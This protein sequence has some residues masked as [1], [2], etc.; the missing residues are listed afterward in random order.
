MLA[1]IIG[2]TNYVQFGRS[3]LTKVNLKLVAVSKTHAEGK[4]LA[5]QNN[6]NKALP[7][8]A[9]VNA[10][11]SFM[12]GKYINKG[13]IV[14]RIAEQSRLHGPGAIITATAY[15]GRDGP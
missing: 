11:Q 1:L 12:E 15:L 10:H 5:E 3:L 14:E 4:A 8:I 7:N 9:Y 2:N 6:Y 13:Y